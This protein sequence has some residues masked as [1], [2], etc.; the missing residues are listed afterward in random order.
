MV[1]WI[2]I[3][4][5]QRL[6]EPVQVEAVTMAV[7]AGAGLG[8][9]L[10]AFAI[11]HR[12]D[13]DNLNLRAAALHV[14]GDRLGSAAALLAAGVIL[15]TGWMPIDPLLSLLVA[16]LIVRS[17]WFVIRK[18]VQILLEGAPDWLDVEQ[19]RRDV[20]AA[21]PA[22]EDVHHVHVGSLSSDRP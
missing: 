7:V 18:S 14:L 2:A 8:V 3:E 12:G 17:A 19:L 1:G 6:I 13:R 21:V 4:A 11:L 20:T 9:N 15:L 22:I 10:A 5:I 16:A